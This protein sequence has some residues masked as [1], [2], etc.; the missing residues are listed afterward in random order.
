MIYDGSTEG[1]SPPPYAIITV[2]SERRKKR[3]FEKSQK[4]LTVKD[5]EKSHNTDPPQVEVARQ[6]KPT[7]FLVC[8]ATYRKIWFHLHHP[9]KFQSQYQR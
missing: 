1:D 2:G 9:L 6:Y 7:V 5:I 8:G 4:S 3:F